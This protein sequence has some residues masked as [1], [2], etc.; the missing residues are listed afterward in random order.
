MGLVANSDKLE[1]DLRKNKA[2]RTDL[3]NAV[4]YLT[5][6]VPW[7]GLTVGAIIVLKHVYSKCIEGDKEEQNKNDDNDEET[8]SHDD[9]LRHRQA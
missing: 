1:G 6:F 7:L 5:P 4:S 9:S 8:L 2:I 3:I